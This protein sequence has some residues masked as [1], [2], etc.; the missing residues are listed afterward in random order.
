MITTSLSSSLLRKTTFNSPCRAFLH[1][2]VVP[3][4]SPLVPQKEKRG[5][6]L[7]AASVKLLKKS[8]LMA[9]VGEHEGAEES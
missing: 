9:A 2:E 3:N 5:E 6:C 1:C 7:A 8:L 4:P